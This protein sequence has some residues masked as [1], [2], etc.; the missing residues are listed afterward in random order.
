M[1]TQILQQQRQQ[2]QRLYLTASSPGQRARID[3][4]LALVEE[5]LARQETA[6]ALRR[7]ALLPARLRSQTALLD[8]LVGIQQRGG[9]WMEEG[10]VARVVD[11]D[12]VLL[13]DGER[14]RYL[15]IDAPELNNGPGKSSVA[16]P[17]SREAAQANARL[18]E[19]K[20]ARLL[21]DQTE[22]DRYGRL[23]R[24]VFCGGVFVNAQLLLDGAARLYILPPDTRF[25]DILAR[26]REAT[27]LFR[28]IS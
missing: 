8:E 6:Q 20:P 13:A 3:G 21:R 25:A 7:V 26:C 22:R 5:R 9:E 27:R 12:T 19:G 14:V 10:R 18:V 11:G 17:G 28:H 23:L 15:G 1:N 16:E 24:Y 4:L 2:I